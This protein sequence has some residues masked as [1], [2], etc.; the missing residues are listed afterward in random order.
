MVRFHAY[1][2]Q[3]IVSALRNGQPLQATL[4]KIMDGI[5]GLGGVPV[6]SW[7]HER[8]ILQSNRPTE[9]V[10]VLESIGA[11][12]LPATGEQKIPH[13]TPRNIENGRP[14]ERI[15]L[16]PDP[17]N[18]ILTSMEEMVQLMNFIQGG[19]EGIDARELLGAVS[20]S[21]TDA[22]MALLDDVPEELKDEVRPLLEQAARDIAAY[23]NSIPLSDLRNETTNELLLWKDSL[24]N[25]AQVDQIPASKVVSYILAQ[26][27]ADQRYDLLHTYPPNFHR[28]T[29]G[30]DGMLVGFSFQMFTL[31]LVR[32]PETKK[33]KIEKRNKHYLGQFRDCL[34]IEE[35]AQCNSFYT[36]DKKAARL[37]EAVYAYAGVQT[38]VILLD[39]PA[40]NP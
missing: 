39:P 4:M 35:A 16:E 6:Y 34:H 33:G 32:E 27:K 28:S 14:S 30:Q 2:D 31:G 18:R 15:S 25:F 19:L 17:L 7:I 40:S 1:L 36:L 8:E 38:E 23:A 5:V 21:A 29:M 9:Y 20:E 22:L 26:L 24:P 3:N 37:A 13:P 11:G 12:Y 10:D